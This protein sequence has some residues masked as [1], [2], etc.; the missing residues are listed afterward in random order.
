MAIVWTQ[1]KC[2]VWRVA[3][4]AFLG[5]TPV[6]SQ[7]YTG[8]WLVQHVKSAKCCKCFVKLLA[9]FGDLLVIFGNLWQSL[10]IFRRSLVIFGNLLRS[11]VI[12]VVLWWLLLIFG[13]LW[14][15]L[16]IFGYLWW[17]LVIFG[18]LWQS[19]VIFGDLWQSLKNF[20]PMRG[21][22]KI[23]WKGDSI[24]TNIERKKETNKHTLRLLNQLG[25]EG[26]VGEKQLNCCSR[27][28]L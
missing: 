16:A 20:G 8:L 1:V 3:A 7:I 26:R 23:T 24:E 13:K 14:Q 10:V 18:D 4:L 27:N 12:F 17:S 5:Q 21:L 22:K 9:I 25:P 2:L 11:L 19:V 6:H 15:T 28:S